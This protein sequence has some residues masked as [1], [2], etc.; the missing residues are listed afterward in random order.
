MKVKVCRAKDLVD[1]QAFTNQD[2]YVKVTLLP[3][4]EE[5]VKSQTC[6]GGGSEPQWDA[7]LELKPDK[8]CTAME[9]ELWNEN[10]AIDELIGKAD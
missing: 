9:L 8:D 2:P 4:R 5:V 6:E 3:K 1:V 7:M 10:V